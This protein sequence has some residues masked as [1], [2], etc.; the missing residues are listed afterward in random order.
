MP[1]EPDNWINRVF[2]WLDEILSRLQRRCPK[3]DGALHR[4]FSFLDK[5]AL[6]IPIPHTIY[7]T[8]ECDEC[9]AH[10]RSYR[11]LTDL[12]LE[13]SWVGCLL[14]LGEWKPLALACTI[15]WLIT[16]S[17]AKDAVSRGMT[18][19][20]CAG[21]LTGVLWVLALVFGNKAFGNFFH[22]H[23]VAAS[24]IFVCL[25]FTPVGIVLV[26]DRYTNFG[27]EELEN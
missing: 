5:V 25:L 16:Y 21:L 7:A 12:F 27:L 8:H 17:L 19:T 22:E 26:L 18:D 13:A 9:H 23:A 15:T 24:P 14:Y 2:D 4:T 3:C 10:F 1:P 11:T 20:L 6:Y